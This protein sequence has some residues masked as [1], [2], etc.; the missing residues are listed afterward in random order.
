MIDLLV[1]IAVIALLISLLLPTLTGVNESARRV[2]CASNVRQ[3]GL[4]VTI[5][6]ESNRGSIP[7]FRGTGSRQIRQ[8]D[9]MMMLRRLGAGN[10]DGLGLLFDQDYLNAPKIFFCPSHHGEHAFGQYASLFDRDAGAE[11]VG[12]YHYRGVGPDGSD[13]LY[14]IE[15]QNAALIADGM[16]TI[17]DYNHRVGSNVLSANLSVRW[18]PDVSGGLENQLAR[19]EEEV[20]SDKVD[21]AWSWLDTQLSQPK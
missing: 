20:A 8:S 3:I 6:A 4:G 16:R 9:S 2:V 12:N 15:P 5:Y 17:F 10:W 14:Q 1:S 18:M 11:I 21:N 19:S 7:L 13:K